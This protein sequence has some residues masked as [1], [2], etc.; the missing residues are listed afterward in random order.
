M[1]QARPALL[2]VLLLL[3][4]APGTPAQTVRADLL[5][6]GGTL[7][8]GTGAEPFVADVAVRDG[9]IVFVGD[10]RAAGVRASETV[11]VTGLLVTPGFID[12]HSHAELDEDWGRDALAFLH[13][14]ITTVV[15]GVDGG[16]EPE[17]GATLARWRRNGLGVNALT[18]VGHG[19]VRR[20]AMGMEDRRPTPAELEDMK[21]LVRQGMEEGA[22]GLSTGLFYTPGSY[23]DTDEV[24]ELAS[25]AAAFGAI[26]DTHDRDLGAAYPG[27]GY[28]ASIR[29]GIEIGERSGARVVFSHFNAQGAHNYGKAPEGARLIREARLRG[30]EVAGAQHVYTATQSSLSAYAIPRWAS[31]GG[32]AELVRRFDHPDTA[33]LLD[34]ETMEMLGVRGGAEK[35][36]F[37]SPRPELN[38]RTLAEVAEGWGLTVPETVRRILRDG[39]AS[40]MNLD[41][42]DPWNTRYLA[43]EPWMMTCTDGRTPEPGQ[44]V[45]HPRVYG[46]FTKKLRDYVLDEKVIGM[47]FAVRSMT[48]L[49]ADF[50]RLPDRGYLREGMAA[51]VAVLD[52]ARV[53]DRATYEAP[54]QLSEG[55]VHVLVNGVFAIR[56]GR[57]TGALA[58]AALARPGGRL[59]KTDPRP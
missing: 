19:A 28:L 39:S 42:Y 51:D 41:L 40:V 1:I 5:L 12:A 38:G 46:A 59:P 6:A 31:A 9:R 55:T 10:A 24:I 37:S 16:G 43:R 4:L 27:I 20:R 34:A 14:G 54:R 45:T 21:R 57:A 22:L 26:Y 13:Q 58:G 56:D 44:V 48:G 17:V 3:P 18:Y 52:A 49:A 32:Q 35:I 25:V 33:R 50:F 29:E 7:H 15:M 30:V 47:P 36:L 23:A 2:A 11:E 53:R 8:D